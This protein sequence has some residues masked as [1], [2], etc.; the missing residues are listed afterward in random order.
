MP[1]DSLV[2]FIEAVAASIVI[3]G[4]IE[5]FATIAFITWFI[6]LITKS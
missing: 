2:Y 3:L 6:E 4:N 5:R 1:G